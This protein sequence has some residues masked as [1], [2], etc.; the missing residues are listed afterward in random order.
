MFIPQKCIIT[1]IAYD[2]D[3]SEMVFRQSFSSRRIQ[4]HVYL[5]ERTKK[6]SPIFSSL[7]KFN[8]ICGILI[9]MPIPIIW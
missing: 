5:N 9:P 8:F 7:S 4:V 2:D 6:N 3:I 1:T